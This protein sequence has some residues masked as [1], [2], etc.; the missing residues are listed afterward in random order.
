MD[1]MPVRTSQD[2]STVRLLRRSVGVIGIAMPFVLA[3]GNAVY[4]RKLILLDSLSSAYYSNMRDVFVGSLCAIGVFLICYRYSLP[5]EL[6]T[7]VAGIFAIMVAVFHPTSD[8]MTIPVT[9]TAR[10]I[11]LIHQAAAAVLLFLMAY[12][13][14]F[15]FTKLSPPDNDK[16][17]KKRLRNVIYCACGIIIVVSLALAPASFYLS[18]S[19]RA[20]LHPLF[21]SE[22][23][24]VVAFGIAWL[25]KG[26]TIFKDS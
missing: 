19:T 20:T 1:A 12:I 13:C 2:A 17:P 10:T 14:L 6:L 7:S 4:L 9:S 25:I 5:D 15:R 23:V 21:W 26:E 24:A 3:I 16:G 22:S 11:G 8:N 18:A